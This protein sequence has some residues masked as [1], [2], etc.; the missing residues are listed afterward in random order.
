MYLSISTKN[1]FME[2]MHLLHGS[3]YRMIMLRSGKI[4]LG[5]K[6]KF[7][8]EAQFFFRFNGTVDSYKKTL[9]KMHLVYAIPYRTIL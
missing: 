1:W 8:R 3:R 6:W 7:I 5:R 4:E 9:E 2:R